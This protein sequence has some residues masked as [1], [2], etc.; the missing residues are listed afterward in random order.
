MSVEKVAVR[1]FWDSAACGETLYLASPTCANYARQSAVR[2][3]LEP[4]IADFAEFERWRSRCVLEIGVGLG[5]DHQ[6]FAAAGA[7]LYGTDLTRRAVDHTRRRLDQLGLTSRLLLGDAEALPFP[8]GTFDLIY[9]WGVFHHSPDTPRAF[10]EAARVL[11]PGGC[12]RIM[13]YHRDSLVG[14]MLWL[15]YALLAGK[16]WR[17]LTDIYAR[18][19]ESPGTKAYTLAEVAVLC[20]GFSAHSVRTVLTHGDLLES[21]AGQRH[22]GSLLTLARALWPRPLIHRFLSDRGLF[23][24]IS[25]IK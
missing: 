19:L 6:R 22:R 17:S 10:D 25:A 5:A 9:A 11:R 4:Y 8:D 14:W 15:R 20:R 1:D 21:A 7:S 2:Y 23:L 18:H 3:R 12:A 16:P 24:L 13:I